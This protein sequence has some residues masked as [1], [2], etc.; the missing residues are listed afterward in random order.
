MVNISCVVLSSWEK[1]ER[2]LSGTHAASGR[3]VSIGAHAIY[4][5]ESQLVGGS[6]PIL[7]FFHRCVWTSFEFPHNPYDSLEVCHL[8][9]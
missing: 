8:L 2:V 6:L 1:G 7:A 4:S 5:W 3:H 9:D